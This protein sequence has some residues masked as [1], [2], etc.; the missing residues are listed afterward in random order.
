MDIKIKQDP[1]ELGKAAGTRAA[2]LIREAIAT[3]GQSTLFWLQ[4][5]ASSKH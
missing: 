2:Q 5:P 1:V 3:R 4:E